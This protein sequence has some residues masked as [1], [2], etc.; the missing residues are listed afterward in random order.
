MAHERLQKILARAGLASRRG[1]EEMILEGRVRVNG[2][3]VDR[4]GSQADPDKDHI[5]VDGK[6]LKL[7]MGPKH[8]YL[9][10]KPRNLLTTLDDPE[11]RPCIK[12]LLR[13]NR[14]RSRVFP[15]GRLDWDADGLLLITNDG[16]LANQVMH[17]RHHLEKHYRVKVRGCPGENALRRLRQGIRIARGP[18]TLPAGIQIERAGEGTT[19]LR[20]TLIEGR[21]NQIKKMF[22]AVGHPVRRLRRMAIGPLRLGKMRVGEMRPLRDEELER[23]RLA[24]AGRSTSRHAKQKSK[25]KPSRA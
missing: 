2:R 3:I 10:F 5:K 22:E 11:G 14:V 23:L 15:V 19:W 16:E 24:L 8:Y 9:A 1:A 6:L 21:Q 4:L 7:P 17:P 20:V 18:R 13:Q 12:D 25:K